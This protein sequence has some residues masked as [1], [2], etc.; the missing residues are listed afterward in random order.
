MSIEMVAEDDGPARA[1]DPET[2]SDLTHMGVDKIDDKVKV[3][4]RHF[5]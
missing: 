5:G 1:R 2:V 3:P 4:P